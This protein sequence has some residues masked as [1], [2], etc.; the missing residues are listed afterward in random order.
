[1][2]QGPS[3]VP[4]LLPVDKADLKKKDVYFHP[5]SGTFNVPVSRFIAAIAL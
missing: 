4:F 1:M 5:H 3:S 2:R